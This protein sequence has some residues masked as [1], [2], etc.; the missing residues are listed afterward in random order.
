MLA[1]TADESYP[2]LKKILDDK[3]VNV[4]NRVDGVGA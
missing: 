2:A 3:F 4:L 1:V